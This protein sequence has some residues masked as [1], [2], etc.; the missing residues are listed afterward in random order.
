M[1]FFKSSPKI[2]APTGDDIESLTQSIGADL[3][4]LARSKT[5]GIFSSAFWSDK[6]MGW[7]MH[8]A[9]F[10]T[11]LFRFVDVMPVLRT[12]ESIH[13]HLV[14]Y[15]TQPG[16]NPPPFLKLGLSAGGLLK[17]TLSKTVTSQVESMGERFVAGVDAASALPALRDLWR[18]GIAFSVDLLGEACL[19]DVE[20]SEYQRRYL[21]L[22]DVLP[23]EVAGFPE[24]VTLQTDH[25]G[26]IPRTNVSIKISS[27][28]ARLSLADFE[29]SVGN[30]A[31]ALEPVLRAAAKNGVFVN[32]DMEQFA[33]KDLT[34]ALFKRCCETVDFSAGLAMQAY[35]R[36]GDADAAE[37]IHWAKQSG[38]AGDSAA[39]QRR[40]LGLR[41]DARAADGLAVTGVGSQDRNRCVLRADG[42]GVRRTDP[43]GGR[44][45]RCK[46]WRSG[47]ITCRSIAHALAAAKR[48]DLPENALG[49]SDAAGHGG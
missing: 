9:A 46:S 42:G 43:D 49:I 20:S 45:G 33:L 15:L 31:S 47:R 5:A 6:L 26:T 19:S 48:R 32:F 28:S 24:N 40:V 22:I 11:Q 10:K 29:G 21:D 3:L 8:N 4:S 39:D 17:G 2:S 30:L 36:S 18:R 37:V 34:I 38:P 12:P 13:Q 23:R 16:V 25:L 7:A 14:E 35:L 1:R 44:S 41:N 27:L